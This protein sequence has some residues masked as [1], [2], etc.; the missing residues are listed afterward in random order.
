MKDRVKKALE[1]LR[2]MLQQDGE[3]VELVDVDAPVHLRVAP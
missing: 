2:P 3:D 1:K